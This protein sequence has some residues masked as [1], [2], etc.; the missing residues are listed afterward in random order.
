MKKNTKMYVHHNDNY[1]LFFFLMPIK[2]NR[3][4]Y[5]WLSM[6]EDQI[7]LIWLAEFIDMELR[8][9]RANGITHFRDMSICRV[10]Y[11][12]RRAELSWNQPHRGLL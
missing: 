4:K 5:S 11:E 8:I 2:R 10:W 3:I 7:F 12:H 6:T 9:Q 1:S